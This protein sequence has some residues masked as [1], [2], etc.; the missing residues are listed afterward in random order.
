MAQR[1]EATAP[2][3]SAM[4]HKR[5]FGDVGVESMEWDCTVRE[6][7]DQ[8][9]PFWYNITYTVSAQG[10]APCGPIC[11]FARAVSSG[12]AALLANAVHLK[13][14]RLWPESKSLGLGFDKLGHAL[15]TDFLGAGTDIANQERN[16]VCLG[17]VMARDESIDGF[18]LMDEAVLQQEIQRAVD[19]GRCGISVA[20]TQVIEQVV[21]FDRLAG[22]R[23]Q[24]QHFLP[25]RR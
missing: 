21:R 3:R 12:L 24:L 20:L 11:R 9:K 2:M 6:R 23:D 8:G 1:N 13:R 7:A 15:I 18:Q 19:R 17:R 4:F 5:E 25:Q 10:L 14:L 16:L 22:C